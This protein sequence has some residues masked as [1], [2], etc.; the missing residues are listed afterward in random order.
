MIAVL[1][2]LV[3]FVKVLEQFG[4]FEPVSLEG[5]RCGGCWP[6]LGTRG[7][8][9]RG[10][11]PPGDLTMRGTPEPSQMMPLGWPWSAGTWCLQLVGASRGVPAWVWGVLPTPCRVL[12]YGDV[13]RG[14][15]WCGTGLVG[16][17]LSLVGCWGRG[18]PCPGGDSDPGFSPFLCFCF[19][20]QLPKSL[21]W[22]WWCWS[23]LLG[24][25]LTPSCFGDG[26]VKRNPPG[27]NPA[28]RHRIAGPGPVWLS[29][30]PLSPGENP[31]PPQVTLPVRGRRQGRGPASSRGDGRD[32]GTPLKPSVLPQPQEDVVSPCGAGTPG[33]TG[34]CPAVRTGGGPRC[35][36]LAAI[37]PSPNR[38]RQ[39]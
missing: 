32:G 33:S 7:G 1:V 5:N 31:C 19:P 35:P 28:G 29:P 39:E 24:S 3:L 9:Q 15:T 11:H 20:L 14:R 26:E 27:P 23:R 6:L 2:V 25:T 13:G 10:A 37:A 38:G 4:L 17:L 36:A 21:Y 16:R 8:H 30:A 18:W 34:I 22:N 12:V